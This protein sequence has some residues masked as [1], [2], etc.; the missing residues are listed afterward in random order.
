MT[1]T[2][3]QQARAAFLLAR[4]ALE[5]LRTP[6]EDGS[7]YLN[8]FA[9]VEQVR[10]AAG[11]GVVDVRPVSKS[12]TWTQFCEGVSAYASVVVG[13][14]EDDKRERSK[15]IVAG[16]VIRSV[17]AD[18]GGLSSQPA[19]DS[20]R[21]DVDV[22]SITMLVL[23]CDSPVASSPLCLA[24]DQLSLAYCVAP[25]WASTPQSPRWRCFIPVAPMAVDG[26]ERGRL[27]AR[28]RYAWLAGLLSELA[29]LPRECPACSG[30]GSLDQRHD[31][32]EPPLCPACLGD[33]TFRFDLSCWNYSR[34][35]FVGGRKSASVSMDGREVRWARG[36]G[37][38]CEAWLQGSGF[39][40]FWAECCAEV[41]VAEAGKRRI[42]GL[43]GAGG[44]VGETDDGL[45]PDP[46]ISAAMSATDRTLLERVR[47][48]AQY[49]GSPDFPASC[50]AHHDPRYG[51]DDLMRA[52]SAVVSGFLVPLEL[53]DE[54]WALRVLEVAYNPRCADLDGVAHP[55]SAREMRK[56]L[57]DVRAT[58]C[59]NAPGYLLERRSD[60]GA[61]FY[62]VLGDG[63]QGVGPEMAGVYNSRGDQLSLVSR[64]GALLD[65]SIDAAL[66]CT[67]RPFD[68]RVLPE[69]FKP[70]RTVLSL[71]SGTRRAGAG[72]GVGG[73]SAA[74]VGA[75]V[76]VAG[77]VRNGTVSAAVGGPGGMG[78]AR[79]GSVAP[80]GGLDASP[81]SGVR[82]IG[83]GK[84]SG[85]GAGL[86]GGLDSS[87]G[88]GRQGGRSRSKIPFDRDWVGPVTIDAEDENARLVIVEQ[89]NQR[90]AYVALTRDAVIVDTAANKA[91]GRGERAFMTLRGFYHDQA[92]YPLR[93]RTQD[94]KTG[95]EKLRELNRADIWLNSPHR[96]QY[97]EWGFA[98]ELSPEECETVD[99]STGS[100]RLLNT[101]QGFPVRPS[102]E[103]LGLVPRFAEL[104]NT[105]IAD[106]RE[107][108]ARYIW[109]WLADLFQRPADK[110]GIAL[111]LHSREKGTGKGTLFET[112]GKLLGRYYMLV[113][114]A[115]Q[116]AGQWN[117]H[118][119]DKLLVFFDE[120]HGLG[121]RDHADRLSSLITESEFAAAEKFMPLQSCKSYARFAFGSNR[122]DGVS[123]QVQDRRYAAFRVSARRVRDAEFFSEL[124]R[125]LYA[126]LAEPPKSAGLDP[127]RAAAGEYR[128]LS[129]LM[130][131][132]LWGVKTGGEGEA[133]EGSPERGG[134]V[135]LRTIPATDLRNN[136]M[137]SSLEGMEA[138]VF[139]A[140]CQAQHLGF[141]KR[142]GV[143]GRAES[144]GV[145]WD[146]QV[147][148]CV[149]ASE[150][151]A[152]YNTWAREHR[153][154]GYH[155]TQIWRHLEAVF[156]STGAEGLGSDRR[157][158]VARHP[159]FRRE[160][161]SGESGSWRV[162]WLPAG[163]SVYAWLARKYGW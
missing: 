118:L 20:F 79:V 71:D 84:G 110:P 30:T 153:A 158:T 127:A 154:Q 41:D 152:L 60:E 13:E 133:V 1:R 112:I 148:F 139:Y 80:A 70:R 93:L 57:R 82:L 51:H 6:T 143:G 147:P 21:T 160:T 23:D 115:D 92:R 59:G 122:E 66:G 159:D 27:Q 76:G 88:S 142:D 64:S 18:S 155:P 32:Q 144:A 47:R 132:L 12:C 5:K 48:A 28:C 113:Q 54:E 9:E 15:Y 25:T 29:G 90:L 69:G 63:S 50:K 123:I 137:F 40:E 72:V 163:P 105:V 94:P 95:K 126:P 38:D 98:P 53:G 161:V 68:P 87:A 145:V 106:G 114:S 75:G 103:G 124:R 35:H 149:R 24:L 107:D 17:A 19:L 11:T 81:G 111:Y 52:A 86:G 101:F 151:A 141:A 58:Q 36:F 146:Q 96:R 62:V 100:R 42:G 22:R 73:L 56:K 119:A 89:M 39:A 140:A 138:F 46:E 97:A 61:V 78:A 26:S 2:K 10:F 8:R 104:V 99:P 134:A 131:H 49:V 43:G 117:L 128:G 121:G 65:L 31:S 83:G 150:F 55:W 130:G 34:L 77:Q 136:M 109:V 7:V 116:V 14:T 162:Y 102:D 129:A 74:G 44:S 125:E 67:V 33:R 4:D 85:G 135:E 156:T 37:L 91:R 16:E 45:H 3:E 120:A 108:W 157:E